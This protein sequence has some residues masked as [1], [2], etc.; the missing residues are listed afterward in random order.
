MWFAAEYTIESIHNW[1]VK[2]LEKVQMRATE[3]SDYYDTPPRLLQ[4]VTSDIKIANTAVQ[5]HAT[6]LKCIKFLLADIAKNV[7]LHLELHTKLLQGGT[8]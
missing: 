3:F 1:L 2:D 7:S 4:R 6:W 5:T 8:V